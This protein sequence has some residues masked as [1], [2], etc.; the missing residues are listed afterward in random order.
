M[1]S[2]WRIFLPIWLIFLRNDRNG[3]RKCPISMWSHFSN[4]EKWNRLSVVSNELFPPQTRA[5][6]PSISH[7]WKSSIGK[8]NVIYCWNLHWDPSWRPQEFV[9][10]MI[11]LMAYSENELI[12]P[13]LEMGNIPTFPSLPPPTS[14]WAVSSAPLDGEDASTFQPGDD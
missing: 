7:R 6:K 1:V 9:L 10:N 4:L 8:K 13:S 12:E 3:S 5:W 14:P 11:E 2:K